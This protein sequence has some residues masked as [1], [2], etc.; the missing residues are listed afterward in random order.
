[1]NGVGA[2]IGVPIRTF[3]NC[4]PLRFCAVKC[5]TCQA[6]ATGE[7]TI[8]NA[9]HTIRYRDARQT[10]ATGERRK[11]DAR[12]AIRDHQICNTRSVQVQ[13]MRITQRIC[14]R[15]FKGDTAPFC[16]IGNI[17]T[18][19][20][21]ATEERTLA[22]ARHAIRDRD[23]RQATAT[24][25][26]PLA[27]ARHTIPYRDTRQAT[28]IGERIIADTRYAVRNRD[29]RQATAFLERRKTDARH[30]IRNRDARQ[31]TA[32]VERPLA[33]ARH[34]IRDRDARQATATGERTLADANSSI[35]QSYGSCRDIT[36]HYPFV[37]IT[38]PIFF[39]N[40]LCATVES[41][42]ADARH[43]IP[44]RDARQATANIERII[45]DTRYAVR[46]QIGR[47]HV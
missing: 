33:D 7:H 22:D 14:I 32:I 2:G 26:R 12:H 31:A 30:A 40:Q 8:A 46:N 21:T 17:Y 25:E 29:A 23:A 39:L 9:R 47:A 36:I 20:A 35:T 11:A 19:Q 15:T 6:T 13:L 3:C 38:D 5:D 10:T 28:A 1:M 34:T 42:I 24:E 16:K 41:I 44:Y 43:T 37:H 4:I 45:T 18:R 27:D